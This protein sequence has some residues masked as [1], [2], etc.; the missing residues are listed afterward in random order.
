MGSGRA[1][2][3]YVVV[4]LFSCRD[5]VLLTILRF[6]LPLYDQDVDSAVRALYVTLEE[7]ICY[8]EASAVPCDTLGAANAWLPRDLQSAATKVC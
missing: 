3:S 4:G 8:E 1:V 2:V 6:Q 5:F 7:H